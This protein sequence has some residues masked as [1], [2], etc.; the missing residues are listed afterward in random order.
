MTVIL[1][2]I[3]ARSASHQLRCPS[4][5][6]TDW[7]L[8]SYWRSGLQDRSIPRLR[9]DITIPTWYPSLLTKPHSQY[10]KSM[11]C[12]ADHKNDH[13]VFNYIFFQF[14]FRNLFLL[15]AFPECSYFYTFPL[16]FPWI[17]LLLRI[18]LTPYNSSFTI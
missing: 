17:L 18:P 12:Q 11:Y 3:H 4:Q 5:H 14:L 7:S 13:A 9:S 15:K 2:S 1:R 10:F 8:R 6:V 16:I